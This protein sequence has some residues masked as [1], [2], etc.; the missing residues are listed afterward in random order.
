MRKKRVWGGGVTGHVACAR[1]KHG[2]E[3]AGRYEKWDGLDGVPCAG[4]VDVC[5]EGLRGVGLVVRRL[6]EDALLALVPANGG[7]SRPWFAGWL[8]KE[9]GNLICMYVVV[10]LYTVLA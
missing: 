6:S 2:D 4:A 5:V 9:R 10:V 7:D 1:L 3:E 8:W